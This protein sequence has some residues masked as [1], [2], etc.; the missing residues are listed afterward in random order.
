MSKEKDGDA[1]QNETLNAANMPV[2]VHSQYIRDLS[3]ENPVAP[4][5]L[6]AG[7][8]MPDMDVN[9]G[10]DARAFDDVSDFPNLYEVAVTISATARRGD[11]VVFIAEVIYGATV[12]IGEEVPEA[13][14][15]PILLIEIPRVTFPFARQIL[16]TMVSQGG[17]PPLLVS[18]VDFN[19]LYFE[20]FKDDI[21]AVESSVKGH[22]EAS[23]VN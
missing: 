11:D 18:P 6:R 15:H 17:F 2:T 12:T 13:Q 3:F 21:A 4:F 8:P 10:M 23:T 7:L 19:A 5:S 14:H 20:R 22:K 16:A 9:I 1:P